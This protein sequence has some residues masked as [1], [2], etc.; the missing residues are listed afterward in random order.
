MITYLL[1]IGADFDM[2]INIDG[3]NE[4]ALHPAENARTRTFA[5]F[6]R[7]WYYYV[8]SLPQRLTSEYEYYRLRRAKLA[9][10]YSRPGLRHSV[11]GNL[12]WRLHD[13]RVQVRIEMAREALVEAA[14]EEEVPGALG[15]ER[16]YRDY[17]QL[18]AH[19]VSIWKQSS[20]QLDR[21]SR[22]NGIAYFHF[23]QPNQYVAGSKPMDEVERS[24]ALNPDHPYR[25]GALVGYP[26]LIAEGADLA[27]R[28]VKFS[29]L[30]QL[31]AETRERLYI[32]D[33]CHFN[34]RGH[35]IMA[36]AIARAIL[37]HFEKSSRG[38][39]SRSP[40]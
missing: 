29:D 24:H 34:A 27:R 3:F 32:D 6:P 8:T 36:D 37:E 12:A 4:V 20:L 11:M 1:G 38:A 15:P 23:L 18:M 31:F 22:A 9:A 26:R 28:G 2:I 7:H 10:A 5:A 14:P 25:R 39:E 30:T 13:R 33:C 40:S 19:L 21:V 16:D 35:Q 17:Q